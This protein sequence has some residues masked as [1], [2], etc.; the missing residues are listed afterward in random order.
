MELYK[1]KKYKH[2][3]LQLKK[4]GDCNH[5]STGTKYVDNSFKSNNE[6]FKIN[7]GGDIIYCAK[8]NNYSGIIM[9][10]SSDY[11]NVSVQICLTNL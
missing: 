7:D 3:Y 8:K 10:N 2:K 4:G 1:Y 11:Y 5:N 6:K 9:D